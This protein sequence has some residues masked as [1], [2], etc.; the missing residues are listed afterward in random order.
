LLKLAGVNHSAEV[1]TRT[2]YAR[3]ERAASELQ[4]RE[5]NVEPHYNKAIFIE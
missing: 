5:K 4:K 2:S 3:G 1:G